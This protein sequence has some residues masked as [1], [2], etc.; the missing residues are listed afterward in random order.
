MSRRIILPPPIKY[1]GGFMGP[2]T[3][4]TRVHPDALNA[5]DLRVGMMIMSRQGFD[6]DPAAFYLVLDLPY[7]DGYGDT[8]ARMFSTYN[9]DQDTDPELILSHPGYGFLA[10]DY[11]LNNLGLAPYPAH[12]GCPPHW[13]LSNYS[14]QYS[15]DA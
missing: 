8:R 15:P 4:R 1:Y 11:W 14:L 6:K 5:Q 3:E 12:N 10:A 13:D 7:V 9:P 2:L